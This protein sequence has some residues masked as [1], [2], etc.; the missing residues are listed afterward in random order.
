[1][2]GHAVAVVGPT[3]LVGQE[4]VRELHR[5]R[6]AVG[7]LGLFG[8]SRTAGVSFSDDGVEGRIALL[9]REAIRGHDLVFMAAGREVAREFA[10]CVAA[11]GA[12]V[13]DVSSALRG[14]EGVALVVPEVNASVLGECTSRI[15]S[16]PSPTSVALSVTLAPL[17]QYWSL[18][19]VV[20]STYQGAAGAGTRAVQ[21]LARDTVRLL[22]A[23]SS[24]PKGGGRP[25]AFDCVP[26][27]G[28]LGDDGVSAHE[29]LVTEETTRILG[30]EMPPLHV[31][32]VRVPIFVGTCLSLVV[33]SDGPIPLEE[34]AAA[35]RSAPGIL[36]HEGTLPQPTPRGVS[37]SS[38]THVGRLR[39]DPTVPH[40]V[41][42]W[43]TIDTLAKGRATNAVQI[44][45]LLARDRLLECSSA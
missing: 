30:A 26:E 27:I 19:R 17:L 9:S 42:L 39:A 11:D 33:E 25:L 5:R 34:V 7:R 15:A 20:V 16:S 10:R 37:G 18:R 4:I 22:N 13:V 41:A 3:G 31:T 44:A 29:R 2:A 36:L 43:V 14:D 35:L 28:A 8:T 21:G 45:E 12:W 32:A 1:M 6:F 38:A 40:G 23:G 24:E